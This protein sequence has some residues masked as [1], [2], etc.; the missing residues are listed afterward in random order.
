M[1]RWLSTFCLLLEAAAGGRRSSC[2]SVACLASQRIACFFFSRN[3]IRA[4]VH[5]WRIS[6]MRGI[7]G[8]EKL[9]PF[10]FS[11]FF[12]WL[13]KFIWIGVYLGHRTES[14]PEPS[15]TRKRGSSQQQRGWDRRLAHA[16]RPARVREAKRR[17]GRASQ[18]ASNERPS[19]RRGM[20][21]GS[22]RRTIEREKRS[23][24]R[25]SCTDSRRSPYK[26]CPTRLRA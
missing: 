7:D 9:R 16:K 23:S 13:C 10:R 11:N 4:R 5:P 3:I 21:N 12:A 17:P 25:L 26:E 8:D 15:A 18:S 24:D 1:R 6:N 20:R 19:Y 14:R 22:I 2:F